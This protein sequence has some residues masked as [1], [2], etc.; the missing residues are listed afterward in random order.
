MEQESD[1]SLIALTTHFAQVQFRLKQIISAEPQHKEGLL[2]E[3]EDF[4]FQG[5]SKPMAYDTAA[6][7]EDGST[8]HQ[9]RH[10]T[11]LMAKLRTQ[12]EELE[13]CAQEAAEQQHSAGGVTGEGKSGSLAEKQ[14]IIIDEL[15][16]RFDLQFGDLEQLR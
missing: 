7:G 12:L 6:A 1:E 11:E 10:R 15:R 16:K 5:C 4:A 13:Q 8:E 3:L 9:K 2:K 14:R